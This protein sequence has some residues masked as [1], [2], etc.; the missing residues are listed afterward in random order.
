MLLARN[1][2]KGKFD[3]DDDIIESDFEIGY[4]IEKERITFKI[5][6]QEFDQ[7]SKIP[8]T[9]RAKQPVYRL[10]RENKNDGRKRKATEY[11][12]AFCEVREDAKNGPGQA[13]AAAAA[14]E[15][16]VVAL[17]HIK[18]NINYDMKIKKLTISFDNNKK[19][20]YVVSHK[21]LADL[22]PISL[23]LPGSAIS[24]KV[25][26][27]GSDQGEDMFAIEIDKIPFESLPFLSPN[28]NLTAGFGQHL[29]A[30][31]IK[32][33]NRTI[34]LKESNH[35]E[36][37]DFIDRLKAKD[38][39]VA[40]K[41]DDEHPAVPIHSVVMQGLSASSVVIDELFDLLGQIIDA[42]VLRRLVLGFA[43]GREITHLSPHV[44]EILARKCT[45]L[46]EFELFGTEAMEE[47]QPRQV[48]HDFF[49]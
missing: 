11:E 28:R 45:A 3:P 9:K 41:V 38:I 6:G 46:E 17:K 34:W 30:S 19:D 42:G 47:Q 25:E 27:K 1:P 5:D 40:N 10:E 20:D 18:I 31:L 22:G 39:I 12:V 26:Y 43:N 2:F 23:H 37:Q 48:V 21:A 29:K 32:V 35:W 4:D 36:P 49:G 7:M 24:L 16:D 8:R 13:G 14:E 15:N 33:N 44:F